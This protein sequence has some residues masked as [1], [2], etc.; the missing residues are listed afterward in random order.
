M[1]FLFLFRFSVICMYFFFYQ[2]DQADNRI[3]VYQ[4]DMQCIPETLSKYESYQLL[5][6]N[7]FRGQQ[8]PAA[9]GYKF[10]CSLPPNL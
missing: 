10:N 2:P 1:L 6:P 4:L 5:G 8:T 3:S 7:C 9:L